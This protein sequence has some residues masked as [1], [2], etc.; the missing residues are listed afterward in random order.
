MY[1]VGCNRR[2]NDGCLRHPVY[3]YANPTVLSLLSDEVIIN[4][5]NI[6]DI[7]NVS[8]KDDMLSTETSFGVMDIFIMCRIN[9]KYKVVMYDSAT[10]TNNGFY[11]DMFTFEALDAMECNGCNIVNAYVKDGEY[12]GTGV[13]IPNVIIGKGEPCMFDSYNEIYKRFLLRM[14][15]LYC[16]YSVEGKSSRSPKPYNHLDSGDWHWLRQRMRT[17]HTAEYNDWIRLLSATMK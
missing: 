14:Y 15:D 1:L 2:I 4:M 11:T 8:I 5:H 9:N 10:E 16:M 17:F 6:D 7:Q 3:D 13:H 12:K